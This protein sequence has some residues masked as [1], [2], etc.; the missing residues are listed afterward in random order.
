MLIAPPALSSDRAFSR[1]HDLDS[2][3]VSCYRSLRCSANASPSEK[4]VQTDDAA[5]STSRRTL[6]ASSFAVAVSPKN[7]Q[8]TSKAMA[9]SLIL[10]GQEK[11]EAKRAN[12]VVAGLESRISTFSLANGMRWIVLER[13]NAPVVSCHT[14]ANVGASLEP[15]GS[16]GVAHLLEHLAF[17]G[18]RLV[19]TRNAAQEAS[20]LDEL[21]EVFYSLRDA[22]SEGNID[23]VRDLKR[24]FE[25][26][27]QL[28]DALAIPNE[29]G[30]LI[31]REGG[32]GLNAQTSQDDTEYFVSLPANKLELWMALE[33]GRFISPV[34]REL[35]SEKEVVKEER[36]LRVDSAPY[37]RFTEAFTSLAFP[38]LPYGRP[39]IGYPDDLERIGRSEVSRFFRENYNP[40]TLTCAVVG[41][42]DP[43]M[44]ERSANHYFGGWSFFD[45]K[46]GSE[47]V[48]WRVD[49]GWDE[50][51]RTNSKPSL[52]LTLPAQPFYIEGYYRPSSSSSDD[53]VISVISEILSG[54][55]LSRFYKNII[56]QGKAL[57]TT[58]VD[59]FPADRMPCLFLTY[60]VPSSGT[61]GEPL[62]R[63]LH[64]E[65]DALQSKGVKEEEIARI[66]KSSRASL[67]EL[68][69][70][71][72]GMAKLLCEYEATTG[73]FQNLFK[74]IDFLEAV[75]SNDVS[76][77]ASLLF[78]PEN[79]VQG[80][81]TSSI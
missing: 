20:L 9:R 62:A 53:P 75:T 21:D 34:F 25:K 59:T 78:R 44:V 67:L 55:R 71:N 50:I 10:T 15:D 1:R 72:S 66:K 14:F 61:D 42:V 26:L 31:T 19:G 35:Y 51:V 22:K 73:S 8:C 43:S 63:F 49:D 41:D 3:K 70:N 7:S 36:R 57:S 80:S 65:L 76:R 64:Q 39:V 28:A 38:M 5:A 45:T 56:L 74:E 13:H 30:A 46:K 17:K 37:G 18:T 68:F 33:S 32:V 47:L 69:G 4:E 79:R 52:K 6:L 2:Q 12:N 48:S 54:G 40:R 58:S 11:E 81:V 23:K 24:K 60:G 16:T 27:Q 29:Y 77:V